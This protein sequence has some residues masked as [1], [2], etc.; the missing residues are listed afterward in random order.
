MLVLFITNKENKC[1]CNKSLRRSHRITIFKKV[2]RQNQVT[3]IALE[4]E[5][6]K[7]EYP[8]YILS[9]AGNSQPGQTLSFGE[10]LIDAVNISQV[11]P[12]RVKTVGKMKF[13]NGP[14]GA[15]RLIVQADKFFKIIHQLKN[16]CAADAIEE[17]RELQGQ[18]ASLGWNQVNAA[19]KDNVFFDPIAHAEMVALTNA[20][21]AV[22][23]SV[24]RWSA[25]NLMQIEISSSQN[26]ESCESRNRLWGGTGLSM[27]ALP[28]QLVLKGTG[29]D[30]G[31][32]SRIDSREIEKPWTNIVDLK[33]GFSMSSAYLPGLESAGLNA[34]EIYKNTGAQIYQADYSEVIKSV[35]DS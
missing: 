22:P 18:V 16:A 12:T 34:F 5:L 17:L 8:K 3:N 31:A 13:A 29:F 15:I 33:T 9:A 14:F 11:S 6:A 30:E 32:A 20:G 2:I 19:D 7:V 28:T 26:C 1:D 24:S 27:Y 4:L 35:L 21:M 25:N 23:L 10:A